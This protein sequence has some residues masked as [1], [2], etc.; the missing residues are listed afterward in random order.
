MVN[1]FHLQTHWI[2]GDTEKL[3]AGWT[4]L[5]TDYSEEELFKF[6]DM[7]VLLLAS[8]PPLFTN[9]VAKIQI[10]KQNNEIS[11]IKSIV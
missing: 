3:P 2:S 9:N 1:G 8:L 11:G 4:G 6:K 7:V 5:Q 10:G